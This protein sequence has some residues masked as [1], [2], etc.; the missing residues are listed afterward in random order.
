MTHAQGGTQLYLKRRSK[1]G[2]YLQGSPRPEAPLLT[3]AVF[4]KGLLSYHLVTIPKGDVLLAWLTLGQPTLAFRDHH[5]LSWA[6]FE[7]MLRN[8]F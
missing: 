4:V 8:A 2:A 6:L 5:F 3:L 1:F 7:T